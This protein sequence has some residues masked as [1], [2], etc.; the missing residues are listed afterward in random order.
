MPEASGDVYSLE[1]G[2]RG[3][4]APLILSGQIPSA[5]P[6]SEHAVGQRAQNKH[7][8]GPSAALHSSLTSAQWNLVF[9]NSTISQHNR[10]NYLRQGAW[11]IS[12]IALSVCQ[13]TLNF[14][15]NSSSWFFTI[16]RKHSNSARTVKN[17]EGCESLVWLFHRI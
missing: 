9:E 12:S 13:L 16:I 1:N 3:G 4:T 17:A 6:G 10:P 11:V 7:S 2:C 15:W 14:I 8:Q 5:I